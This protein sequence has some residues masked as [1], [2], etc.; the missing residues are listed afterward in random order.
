MVIHAVFE[1]HGLQAQ[2]RFTLGLRRIEGY[3]AAAQAQAVSVDAQMTGYL[4]AVRAS[5]AA[6]GCWR[7]WALRRASL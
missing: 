7:R 3:A 1:G 5:S 4:D 6:N 2:L